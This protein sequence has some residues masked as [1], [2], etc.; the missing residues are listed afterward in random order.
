MNSVQVI[1][2]EKF[3]EL[4]SKNPRLSVRYF[5]QR[6]GISSGALSEILQGKRKVS[7]KLAARMAERLQLD[8]TEASQFMGLPEQTEVVDI[9]YRQ[10]QDDQFHMLSDWPHFAILN[11][12]KSENC[13][14]RPSWFAKQLNLPLKTIHQVLERL[15]R[16]EMLVYKNKK[17]VR[18][19]PHWKTSDDILN[20]SIQ[21]SNLEDLDRI[22]EQ[23]VDLS[24]HERDLTSLT[25]L[26]DPKKMA[27]FKKWIRDAQDQFA[28]K[29]ETTQSSSAFRLTVA[30]FPLKKSQ[31]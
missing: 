28:H 23:V 8:P 24:V 10:L 9:Q 15:L 13:V 7:Q 3:T 22:R 25:M 16:L 21:R 4:R 29:F 5:A 2:N 1:L 19:S 20:L 12:V 18:S 14:H 26:L 17:Y 31:S 6:L 11:L 30:L 27:I